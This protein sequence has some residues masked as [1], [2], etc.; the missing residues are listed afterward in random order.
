MNIYLLA[1]NDCS[2]SPNLKSVD[3]YDTSAPPL[4]GYKIVLI[5]VGQIDILITIKSM[6]QTCGY[7]VI[8]FND[9][10]LTLQHFTRHSYVMG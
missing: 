8:A 4:W 5:V 7:A 9:P 1:E 2:N 3:Y 10:L 6:F